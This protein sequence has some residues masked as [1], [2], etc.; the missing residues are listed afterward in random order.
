MKRVYIN[1][2]VCIGCRLC[3]VHCRLE[4][5]R[6]KDLIKAFKKESPSPSP[7]LRVERREVLSFAVPCRH[8]PEPYCVYACLTGALQRQPENGVI[9]VDTAKCIG[10]WTCILACP[11]GV[12]RQER[13]Q[14]KIAKCDLCLERGMPACVA[15]CPNEALVYAETE[16]AVAAQ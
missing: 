13:E 1:E 14:G 6:S 2:E 3:E 7:L 10:C 9:T 12:I 11:F 15:N 4:H 5:S 8:C 16:D